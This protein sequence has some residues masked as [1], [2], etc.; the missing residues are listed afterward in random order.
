[1]TDDRTTPESS[2]EPALD[3]S[4]ALSGSLTVGHY[5]DRAVVLAVH[6]EPDGAPAPDE[7][8]ANLFV[9]IANGE[10]VD[11]VRVDT[12]HDDCHVDRLYLP[13]GHPDRREDYSLTL[14]SPEEVLEWLL[15]ERRW[16]DFVERYDRNHGL[17]PSALEEIEDGI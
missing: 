3:S 11:V 16:A 5:D 13:R 12:A 7:F 6:R 1:M 14:F 8:G 9:P 4:G 17:P 2:T 15:A 10:N